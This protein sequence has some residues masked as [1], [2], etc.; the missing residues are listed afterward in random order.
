TVRFEPAERTYSLLGVFGQDEIALVPGRLFATLG[1]KY[2]HNAFSG[3]DFQPNVRG[4]WLISETQ[5]IWGA[6]SH[7]VRRPTRLDDDVRFTTFGGGF[8]TIT[9]NPDFEP[10]SVIATEL[11]YR[12]Q[13][14]PIVSVDATAFHHS[15]DR[16][17]SIEAPVA[18]GMPSV[19]GNTL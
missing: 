7:A 9:G 14:A 8:V 1:A 6:V 11:G 4:R 19:F 18:P 5:M 15:F 17:R 10:E 3:G 12:I 2:E 13:P 16:L